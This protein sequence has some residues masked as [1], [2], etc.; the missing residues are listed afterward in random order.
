MEG[1]RQRREAVVKALLA[2]AGVS[3]PPQQLLLRGFKRD[4]RLEVWAASERRGELRHVATY[5]FCYAS[6]DLGPKRREGDW[7][8]PEGFY[9]IGFF[10]P[11]SR[12]HLSMQ[13]SY[14]NRSD[15]IL[16]HPTEP[17]GEI[18]IHGSCVSVG[19]IA[20]SDARI[21]ELWVL[22]RSVPPPVHVHLFPAR[23]MAGLLAADTYPQHHKLWTNL[24][25]GLDY[26]EEHRRI[27]QVTVSPT[28]E[29]RFQ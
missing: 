19:C 4:K 3:F 28:G 16:G 8:V 9:Q 24:K 17:G 6:G 14:P 2:A 12:F 13:I 22:A 7:Q 23:D 10:N 15:R 20:L 11:H 21:E 25:Q 5:E 18:M 26:F 27:P 1:A 29:Y